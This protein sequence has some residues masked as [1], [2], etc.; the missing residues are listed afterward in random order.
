MFY[1]DEVPDK[2]L[3]S[4]SS[5]PWLLIGIK[6]ENQFTSLTEVVNSAMYNG[7]RVTPEYLSNVTGFK[8]GIWQYIDKETLEEKDFPSEGFVIKND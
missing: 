2:D 1:E 3:V 6:Y 8:D 4:L 7:V 5:L